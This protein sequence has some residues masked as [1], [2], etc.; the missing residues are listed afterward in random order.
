MARDHFSHSSKT[1]L[2]AYKYIPTLK[3]HDAECY[4]QSGGPAYGALQN[5]V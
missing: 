5:A 4:N 1:T 2:D 3:L